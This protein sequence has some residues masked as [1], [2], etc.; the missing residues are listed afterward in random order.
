MAT[1]GTVRMKRTGGRD[2]AVIAVTLG[3]FRAEARQKG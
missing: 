1:F 2:Q 3:T